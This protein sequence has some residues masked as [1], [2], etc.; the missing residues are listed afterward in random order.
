[1]KL[2]IKNVRIA[3]PQLWEAKAVNGEGKPAFSASFVLPKD[4]PQIKEIND[5]IDQLG[6]DKWGD[7]ATAMLTQLRA[8]DKVALHNGDTKAQY[9]GFPGNFYV[10]ARAYA[11]PGVFDNRIDAATGKVAALT[12]MDGRPY[13]G[14]YVNVTVDLWP[15]D[16]NFG[17]RINATLLG[18]QFVKDGAAFAGTPPSSADDFETVP[19]A[20]ETTANVA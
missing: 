5:A 1:M 16:N 13:G 15:Q 19:E 18:V 17:K 20:D 14:C 8:A 4:H 6:K 11:R 2:T 7:K 10:S 3:F 9:D 12:Q